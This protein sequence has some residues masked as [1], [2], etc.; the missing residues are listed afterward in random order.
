MF[1][2]L[3]KILL[4][5]VD[6][7][8]RA[9]SDPRAERLLATPA[10]QRARVHLE[11]TDARTLE[12][13]IALTEIPAPPFEEALRGQHMAGLMAASGLN[14]LTTDD[15]GNVIAH[16]PGSPRFV[17]PG[18]G[19]RP[20]V[21][22][23]HLDTVFPA[24]TNTRVT[25]DGDRLLGPG[26][27]DD[28]RGLAALLALSRACLAAGLEFSAPILVVATVGEEG[29]GDLRGVRHLFSDDG[30]LSGGCTCFFSLDG[31]GMRRIVNGGLGSLR[32]RATV[33]GPG[34]HS[35]VDFGL[36][37]PIHALARA[38]DH[39]T[40][41]PLPAQPATTLS[42]GRW[43][44]GTSVNAIPTEA[45]VEF[46]VRSEAEVELSRMDLEVRSILDR[47]V[48]PQSPDPRRPRLTLDIET[49]GRRPAGSTSERHPLV[50]A[51]ISATTALGERPELG[52][53]STDANLP[54]SMGV[55]A[56][57]LGVGGEAGQAH[58]TGEW[59]RNTRGPDGLLRA[60]LAILL[61]DE[62]LAPPKVG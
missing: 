2:D 46:E 11:S 16:A 58:T 52:I 55:P 29:A 56:I 49:L 3:S 61:A 14:V 59:Y 38:I 41:V 35:W 27:S 28:A 22:S 39:I 18:S 1:S 33:R 60:L 42:V 24:G 45:W 54:M 51:A 23:A 62:A 4:G 57:T 20:I 34:G 19:G 12:E 8:S 6:I 17:G 47:A 44:G 25:R 32:Y 15:V 40:G 9:R 7:A 53:S 30:V 13:Q 10:V 21:V 26:I 31:A 5:G 36:P 37:N 43:G 50:Q 48:R